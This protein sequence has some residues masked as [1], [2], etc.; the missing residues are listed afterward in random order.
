MAKSR[1]CSGM[2]NAIYTIEDLISHGVR[3]RNI[4]HEWFYDLFLLEACSWKDIKFEVLRTLLVLARDSY[5]TNTIG[6]HL[7]VNDADLSYFWVLLK[8]ANDV[9]SKEPLAS[10]KNEK[11]KNKNIFS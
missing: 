7:F 1:L 5:Y 11:N 9:L 10:L 8:Q 4:S 6:K 2:D 3:F